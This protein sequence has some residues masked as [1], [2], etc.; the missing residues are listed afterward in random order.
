MM[1]CGGDNIYKPASDLSREP[2]KQNSLLCVLF[3]F[4]CAASTVVQLFRHNAPLGESCAFTR[5]A[6][7]CVC[8]CV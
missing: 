6:V 8:V 7:V 4:F 2:E 3:C 1:H 5:A